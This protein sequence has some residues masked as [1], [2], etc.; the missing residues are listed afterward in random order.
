MNQTGNGTADCNGETLDYIDYIS[1]KT[2]IR[3]F[4]KDGDI[5]AW[6]HPE[7]DTFT[8]FLTKTYSSPPTMEHFEISDDYEEIEMQ[9]PTSGR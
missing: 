5:Y 6:R 9:M 3:F 1:D 4:I 8:F 2:P 7:S